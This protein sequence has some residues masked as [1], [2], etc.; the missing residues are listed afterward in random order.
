MP[1]RVSPT[2]A[3]ESRVLPRGFAGPLNS[4]FFQPLPLHRIAKGS[5]SGVGSSCTASTQDSLFFF[6]LTQACP[7]S[8]RE[9]RA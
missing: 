4:N 1:P 8:V 3:G 5:V 6:D 7:S 2:V 9:E